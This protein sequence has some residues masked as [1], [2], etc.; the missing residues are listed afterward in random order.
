M[1]YGSDSSRSSSTIASN[2]QHNTSE[3]NNNI[4]IALEWCFHMLHTIVPNI[5]AIPINEFDV[6]SL[7]GKEQIHQ[8]QIFIDS[9][10]EL[11]IRYFNGEK[12]LYVLNI[13]EPYLLW[14]IS[15]MKG[16]TAYGPSLYYL[17]KHYEFEATSYGLINNLNQ[18]LLSYEKAINVWEE[19][20]EL[21]TFGSGNGV[22]DPY[23]EGSDLMFDYGTL[24]CYLGKHESGINF[25]TRSI[26][27][28]HETWSAV[29]DNMIPEYVFEK[30]PVKY[31]NLA[32]CYAQYGV[33]EAS[34]LYYVQALELYKSRG[35]IS[36]NTYFLE[37]QIKYVDE[38]LKSKEH[39]QVSPVIANKKEDDTLESPTKNTT[40][41]KFRRRKV[42]K[43]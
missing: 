9:A 41:K 28:V 42:K 32:V 7:H 30:L 8:I 14:F 24:L 38:A 6:T 39:S 20:K 15:I 25:L 22:L 36:E 40:V 33:L 27:L 1:G 43:T 37:D 26:K 19:M 23:R 3:E 34:R 35:I 18:Q 29:D 4:I 10:Y 2:H 5:T 11:M 17:Y 12:R 31:R 16:S 13:I 21:G